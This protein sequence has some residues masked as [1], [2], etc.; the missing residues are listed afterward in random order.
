MCGGQ[1]TRLDAPVEKPL[2]E[3]CDTPMIDHVLDAL[4]TST[5]ETVY[6]VTSPHTPATR[7]H[8]HKRNCQVIET[9][10]A[11]YVA[12]LDTALTDARLDRPVVTCVA[13]LPLLAG[14]VID[15]VLE[16]YDSRDAGSLTIAVPVALKRAIGVSVDTTMSHGEQPVT[17]VGLNVV[18][19]GDDSVS[20]SYDVRVAVNV[21]RES[22]ATVANRLCQR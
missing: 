17:P 4:A 9:D 15:D 5:V 10:G 16:T 13:D 3:V 21:N 14:D 2:F 20:L 1:G 18:G 8:V 19:T 12:D 11:G 7:E 22:D 6:A